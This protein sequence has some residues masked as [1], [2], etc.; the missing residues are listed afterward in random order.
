LTWDEF[1]CGHPELDGPDVD[2][3]LAGMEALTRRIETRARG[4]LLVCAE[5]GGISNRGSG[6]RAFFSHENLGGEPRVLV[7]C[8]DCAKREFG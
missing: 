1:L 2:S 7:F 3:V 8:P 5:C 6:W 4:H